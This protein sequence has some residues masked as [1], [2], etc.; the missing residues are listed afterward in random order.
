MGLGAGACWGI[1]T[2][3]GLIGKLRQTIFFEAKHI[4]SLIYRPSIPPVRQKTVGI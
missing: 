1:V 4:Q 3:A 2:K